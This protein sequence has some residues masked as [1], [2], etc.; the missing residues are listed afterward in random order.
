MM[1]ERNSDKL[2]A[3][4]LNAELAKL[5]GGKRWQSKNESHILDDPPGEFDHEQTP[6]A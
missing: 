5:R 4:E 2:N 3:N 6:S 1:S